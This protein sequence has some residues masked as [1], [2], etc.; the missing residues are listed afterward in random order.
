MIPPPP[1]ACAANRPTAV[2]KDDVVAIRGSQDADFVPDF[3]YYIFLVRDTKSKIL[4][5][6]DPQNV[7]ANTPTRAR[8]ATRRTRWHGRTP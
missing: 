6:W 7:R 1:C 8:V 4:M 2:H 5:A 3:S